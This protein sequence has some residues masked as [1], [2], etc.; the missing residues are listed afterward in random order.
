MDS[1]RGGDWPLLIGLL[2]VNAALLILA[3]LIAD[4]AYHVMDPR[5]GYAEG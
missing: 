3:N 5:I 4:L 1:L 2:M